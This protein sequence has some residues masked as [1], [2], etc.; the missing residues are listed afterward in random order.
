MNDVS[1]NSIL[2]VDDV[3]ENIDILVGLLSSSYTISAA[4]SGEIALKII[5]SSPPDLILLDILMPEMDGYEVCKQLRSD[6]I[7]E[8]IPVVFV[9]AADSIEE[10]LKGYDVGGDDYVV[11]PFNSDELI[12]KINV[13]LHHKNEVEK[14]ASNASEAMK[15]AMVAMTSA[16]E[17]GNVLDFLSKSF[18]CHSSNE[19]AKAMLDNLYGNNLHCAVQIRQ[20][21][22]KIN[23]SN[24]GIASPLEVAVIDKL[25]DIK[26]IYDFGSRTV[27]NYP[28]VSLL[29]K[30][31]P[32]DDPDL[33]GRIK[34]N[35]AILV[36]GAEERIKAISIEE[37]V[38]DKQESL[39]R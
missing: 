33:Y 26:R 23:M 30:N 25:K 11:K 32:V 15:V 9:S 20:G 24:N 21:N 34:D 10:R 38:K 13:L 12:K 29:I 36:E 27:I 16:G 39:Q 19:L 7:T 2:I 4:R 18:T 6:P 5:R 28:H 22:N 37:E 35:I 1:N 8:T 31:M 17:L 3:P 14:L